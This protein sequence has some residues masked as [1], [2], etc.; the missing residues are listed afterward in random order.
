MN[1]SE[2]LDFADVLK[3]IF[4]TVTDEQSLLVA[5]M[6]RP[7]PLKA[8]RDVL[9]DHAKRHQ[10][11]DLPQ[12]RHGLSA[13]ADRLRGDGPLDLDQLPEPPV[14]RRLPGPAWS[15]PGEA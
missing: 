3:G 6:V 14:S 7:L 10:W 2:L 4:P 8:A 15:V 5:E 12:L 9:K 1:D 11:L 13:A